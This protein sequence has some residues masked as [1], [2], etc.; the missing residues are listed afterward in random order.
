MSSVI[1]APLLSILVEVLSPS[2]EAID[3]RE[4]LLN[5]PQIPTVEEYVLV[6]QDSC[7][8]TIHRRGE[9]WVP[10]LLSIREGIAEFRSIELSIPLA[11]IYEGAL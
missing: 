5:C 8:M 11:L 1:T 4:K 6:A 7:E 3:R 10:Q 2:T 9:R